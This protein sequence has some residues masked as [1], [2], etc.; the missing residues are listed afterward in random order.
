MQGV[1][2]GRRE[3]SV[4]RSVEIILL[5]LCLA[6][7]DLGPEPTR[8]R[9]GFD[10]NGDSAMFSTSQYRYPTHPRHSLWAVLHPA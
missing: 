5:G 3:L 9:S 10:L 7:V 4:D 8:C 1:K 2:T 6:V